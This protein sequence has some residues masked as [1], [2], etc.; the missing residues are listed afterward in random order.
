MDERVCPHCGVRDCGPHDTP[1]E[2][3]AALREVIAMLEFRIE[4]L[5]QRSHTERSFVFYRGV[6]MSLASAARELGI[7]PKVLYLRIRRRTGSAAIPP[8]LDLDA[9]RIE[10]KYPRRRR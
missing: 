7:S 8:D 6:R 2:C 1:D 4:R 5:V 10:T 9:L 3:I